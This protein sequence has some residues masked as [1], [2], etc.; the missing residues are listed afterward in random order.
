MKRNILF[1]ALAAIA[2]LTFSCK[3]QNE[4]QPETWPDYGR[5]QTGN[6]WIY[7]HYTVDTL[8]NA[9]PTGIFDSCY[10]EK[11]TLINNK[12]YA[13]LVKPWSWGQD[14]RKENWFLRDSMHYIVDHTGK[15][16]FS[17]EDFST[18]FVTH[19]SIRPPLGDTLYKATVKMDDKDLLISLPAGDYITCNY[20]TVYDFSPD[21]V[22]PVNPRISHMRYSK[23]IGLVQ[24]TL[25]IFASMPT[26][27]E[28][29]LVR[30]DLKPGK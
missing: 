8:Q 1:L 29:R 2:L 12:N 15:I 24:E 9:T 13:K 27:T 16:R 23:D 30:Y 19:Y 21:F 18:V 4:D 22:V 20:K 17:S 25:A 11:D 14:D 7:E 26:T 5:L 3:E 28:R 6:Y 10:V